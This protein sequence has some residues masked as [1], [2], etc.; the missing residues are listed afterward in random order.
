VSLAAIFALNGIANATSYPTRTIKIIVPFAAG[1]VGDVLARIL[2]DKVRAELGQPV[3]V[4]NRAGG[5]SVIGTQI[6]ARSEP[7]GYTVLQLSA[8]GSVIISL[9]KDVTYNLQRDFTPVVEVASGPLALAVSGKSN[10]HSVSELIAQARATPGGVNYASGGAGSMG[11]L[12]AALLARE[13]QFP[14]AHIAYRGNGPA[15]QDL[16]ADRVQYFFPTVVDAI[17]LGKSG[18]I[19]LLAVTSEE[20]LP[21]LPNVPTMAELG[22]ADF[23]PVV[24]YGYLVPA[25]TPEDVV[26]RLEKTFAKAVLD[27][28]VQERLSSL[29]LTAKVAG[30]A[31]FGR[32][33]ES[34][35][36][37]W[38]KVIEENNIRLEN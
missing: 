35:S 13:N 4:E 21:S 8:T 38:R 16:L 26:A 5:N 20:R 10:A 34:E 7:D 25:H 37:R 15:M 29:G 11:H 9:Q 19:R 12:A 32:L 18:Q 30:P 31:E 17:E 33:I 24:W 23:N 28:T 14:A 2:A 27:P 3:I 6:A 36:A 1:G 22:F